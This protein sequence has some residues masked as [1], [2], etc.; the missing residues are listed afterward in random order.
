KAR[1]I[2]EPLLSRYPDDPRVHTSAAHLF[3]K[4]G[5]IARAVLEY[6]K[7][8][9]LTPNDSQV[10]VNLSQVYLS[11]DDPAKAMSAAKQALRIDPSNKEA[12]VCLV[13]LLMEK[14][15][16]LQADQEL[17]QLTSGSCDDAQVHYL[18]AKLYR[19]R[20]QLVLALQH[21]DE[22]IKLN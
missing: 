6:E 16:Y 10:F 12:R 1:K 15:L 11:N 3:H 21:V 4:M 19:E 2:L 13:K 22:A 17:R 7:V 8:A 5:L 18:A 14:G 20:G 9:Q